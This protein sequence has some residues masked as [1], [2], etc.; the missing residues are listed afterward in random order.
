M[1]DK[2]TLGYIRRLRKLDCC[3]VSDA[4]DRLQLSGVVSGVP[5]LSGTKLI[6][7]SII[8]IKLGVDNLVRPAGQS[9]QQHLGTA[10]IEAGG[11]EHVIVIEQNTG[12]EA[13]SWGGLL[14]IGAIMRG[15]NGV[16]SSGP[17]RDID[18]A[19][20]YKFPVFASSLTSLTARGR[21]VEVGT[22]LPL[23]VWGFNI[24]PGDFV[25]ADNSSII[26]IKQDMIEDVLKEAESIARQENAMANA[27]LQGI[28]ISKVL[29]STYENMIKG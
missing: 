15:I 10:A 21:I 8:T 1:A 3:A 16:I 17:V 6:A 25:I 18:Q 23:I 19:R 26:L 9:R 28:T 24:N 7:G 27:I 11:P 5:Q 2:L 13:A 29:G 14:T 22:N 12:I 4:L 20:K